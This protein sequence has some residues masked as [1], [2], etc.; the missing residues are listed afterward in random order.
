MRTRLGESQPA[1][2]FAGAKDEILNYPVPLADGRVLFTKWS[3]DLARAAIRIGDENGQTKELFGPAWLPVAYD[4]DS[5]VLIYIRDYQ[6]HRRDLASGLNLVLV[7][8]V[9]SAAPSPR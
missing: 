8:Y 3:G 2:R 4:P 9:R 7:S 1:P 5:N 6:L